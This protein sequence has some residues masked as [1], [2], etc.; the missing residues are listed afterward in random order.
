MPAVLEVAMY[1][2]V[3]AMTT[4]SAV[5][6]LCAPATKLASV[7]VVDLDGAGR[8]Q[9]AAAMSVLIL[10]TNIAARLLMDFVAGPV[11]RRTQRWRSG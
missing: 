4:V 5:I 3:S 6:F 2:F 9:E 1:Y 7:A 11:L 8:E 10:L